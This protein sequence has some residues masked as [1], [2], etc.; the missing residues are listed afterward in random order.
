MSGREHTW[1]FNR[2]WEVVRG[3][4]YKGGRAV[5]GLEGKM[6]SSIAGNRSRQK[7]GRLPSGRCLMSV[8]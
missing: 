1:M 3:R 4:E 5:G 2:R 8:Y 7:I 6:W